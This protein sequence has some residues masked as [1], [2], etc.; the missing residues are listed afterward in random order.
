MSRIVEKRLDSIFKEIRSNT[1]YY[2]ILTLILL[3]A[4]FVRTYR[5]SELLQFYY[6]QG[7]DALVIWDL[8]HK[9]EPFLVGPVTGLQ[10]IFLGPFYYYL[11]APFYLIGGGNPVVPAYFLAFLSTIALLVLYYL[12]WKMHSRA[13]GIIAAIVGAFSYYIV[14]AG[15]WLSNPTPILLTSVLLLWAMWEIT[16]QSK[17]KFKAWLWFLIALLVGLSMQFESASA[18]FYLPMI[19]TFAI[20]QYK[21][22]P[23]FKYLLVAVAIFLAT[24]LPQVLFNLRNENI[25]VN[26]FRRVVVEEESFR[27]VWGENMETKRTYFLSVFRSK[28]FPGIVERPWLYY[29]A[30]ILG[31]IIF[32]IKKPAAASIFAIYLG[33]PMFGYLFFQG[34]H[35]NIYDYYMSGY[36]LP[37]I[38]LFSIGLGEVWKNIVGKVVVVAFLISFLQLNGIVVKN[39]LMTGTDGPTHISLGNQ[40]QAVDWVLDDADELGS[41]NLDVYVPPVI[42]HS[43]DYLFLWRGTRKCGESLCGLLIDQ[44][45]HRLYTFYEVD[46]PHPERLEAWLGKYKE[47]TQ[48]EEEKTF[49]GII[50]QRRMRI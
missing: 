50:V 48:V 4:H 24:L 45:V 38:L 13:S 20:W 47:D 14:L 33:V 31:L 29:A 25:L 18:I 21:N 15:R 3:L 27:S 46:P 19:A 1:T 28:I 26:N 32:I 34:N 35:G 22:L 7:R 39:M 44:T 49:G 30:S 5:T 17:S 42:P 43:Y 12:G 8:W 11:I 41:F 9:G 10:G 6:D 23:R 16:Q 40:L 36:Y 37:M 2:L